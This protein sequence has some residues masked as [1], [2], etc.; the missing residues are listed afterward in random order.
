MAQHPAVTTIIAVL[1]LSVSMPAQA[2]IQPSRNPTQD[3]AAPTA[4]EQEMFTKGQKLYLQGNYTQAAEVLVN[5][6]KSYPNSIITDLTLLWLGR[7]YYQ[8]GKFTEAVQVSK[9]LRAIK[10]TPFADIYDSELESA[11][12][13]AASRQMSAGIGEN[14]ALPQ[15]RQQANSRPVPVVSRNR[16]A[17]DGVTT[18]S[19]PVRKMTSDTA[20]SFP[21][22][23]TTA[24]QSNAGLK[25]NRL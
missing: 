7:S 25:S 16:F 12:R 23:P 1:I 15:R 19:S 17:G 24:S 11:R 14:P 13:E 9:R 20:K 5:F 4:A 21:R 10:D 8:L 22:K 6:L 18:R 2:T 3:S